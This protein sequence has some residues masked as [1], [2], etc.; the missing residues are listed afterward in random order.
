MQLL[1]TGQHTHM[2]ICDDVTLL[3]LQH[4]CKL[5]SSIASLMMAGRMKHQTVCALPK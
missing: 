4:S 5:S 1:G 3:I 2:E